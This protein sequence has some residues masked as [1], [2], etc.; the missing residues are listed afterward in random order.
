MLDLINILNMTGDGFCRFALAMFIQSGILIALL[1]LI[2]LLIRKYVRAVFRYC[3]WMLVFIKLILPPTLC[4]PTGIGYWCS[5]DISPSNNQ[6]PVNAPML[7]TPANTNPIAALPSSNLPKIQPPAIT[8]NITSLPQIQPA[9]LNTSPDPAIPNPP[10]TWQ[11]VVFLIWLVGVLILSVLLLQ[12]FL[13]VKSLL[14]QTALADGRLDETLQQCR[15]QL[16]T[17]QNVKLRLSQNMLSPAACGLF[18]PVILMS[19]SLLENLSKEKLTAILI[20]ELAH[21]K[22]GD[23]WINFIQT[24]LQILYFYN[25]FVWFANSIVRTI[26]E[27]AVDEMVLTKLGDQAK[28]YSSTLIDIAELAFSKPH[29]SLRLVGVVESKKALSD[30]IKHIL[31]RPIPK[32]AKLGLVGL[33]M[34]ILA[35]CVL[36]PMAKGKETKPEFVVKDTVKDSQISKLTAEEL[37]NSTQYKPSENQDSKT[38]SISAAQTNVSAKD[39]NKVPKEENKSSSSNYAAALHKNKI[40]AFTLSNDGL[41]ALDWDCSS[42]FSTG[43]NAKFIGKRH[44]PDL[45]VEY[46]IYFPADCD[47]ETN[48]FFYGSS[49]YGGSGL[50][51]GLNLPDYNSFDIKFTLRKINDS[52][53]YKLVKLPLYAGVFVSTANRK[54]DVKYIALK[55]NRPAVASLRTQMEKINSLGILIAPPRR[56]AGLDPNLGLKVTLLLQPVP[57]AKIIEPIK[58]TSEMPESSGNARE[59]VAG[60]DYQKIQDA[61][62]AAQYGDNV[63]IKPGI[64]EESLKLKDGVNLIGEDTN[65]VIIQCDFREA[66]V[67]TIENCKSARISKMTL[68]HYSSIPLKDDFAGRWAVIRLASSNAFLEH[69]LVCD[70]SSEG[71]RI[72]NNEKVVVNKCTVR[73]SRTLGILVCASGRTELDNNICENNKSNGIYFKGWSSGIVSGNLC[74][75]NA[76]NGISIDDNAAVNLAANTCSENKWSGIWL[77]AKGPLNV[78]SNIC[79]NNEKTGIEINGKIEAFV[80]GNNCNRNSNNG[81]Y[82]LGGAGG[83]AREN[84]CNANKIH[85]ISIDDLS[86]PN[87]K[88]NNCSDNRRCGVYISTSGKIQIGLNK[89]HNNGEFSIGEIHSLLQAEDFNELE[90]MASKIRNEKRRFLDGNWQLN[91]FYWTLGIGY[92]SSKQKLI[93]DIFKKWM[94]QYPDSITPRICMAYAYFDFAWNARGGGFA[95][96]VSEKGWRE[97]KEFLQKAK[98][99]LKDAEKFPVKDPGLYVILLGIERG[100]GT[101]PQETQSIFEK[102]VAIES[103]YYP[104]YGERATSYMMR[105]YGK[106]GDLER[107]AQDAVSRTKNTEGQILY[108]LIAEQEIRKSTSIEDFKDMGFNYEQLKQGQQELVKRFPEARNI[109]FLNQVCF[110]ACAA[111]NKEDAKDYFIDIGDQW[112]KNIWKDFETFSKYKSWAKSKNDKTGS[113]EKSSINPEPN[114]IEIKEINDSNNKSDSQAVMIFEKMLAKYKEIKTFSAVGEV[115]SVMDMSDVNIPDNTSDKRFQEAMKNFKSTYSFTIKLGRPNLYLVKWE[116]KLVSAFSI[117]SEGAVWNAGDGDYLLLLGQKSKPQN[118]EMALASA[119]GVSGGAAATIPSLFFNMPW[120]NIKS[121]QGLSQTGEEKIDGDDCYIISGKLA[122]MKHKLWISKQTFLIRQKQHIFNGEEIKPPSLS[123]EDIKTSLKAMGKDTNPEEIAKMRETMQSANRMASKIKA[124]STTEIYLDIKIDEAIPKE[125]FAPDV[126]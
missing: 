119:T 1:Y 56:P 67:L 96:T 84:I 101:L 54:S 29:F 112:D 76:K 51:A 110:T 41:M 123:D 85:G 40:R 122:N 86:T 6:I 74:R 90:Y 80:I 107:F 4:L 83:S 88:D 38:N 33:V 19:A 55:P 44:I 78:R 120:G 21:I 124:G 72:E 94:S 121:M 22:R 75:N 108:F 12:K 66:P 36:L 15:R 43:T 16:P 98:D 58:Q 71:I 95:Y 35:G 46:D 102:G 26:R 111:E 63:R 103:N 17:R 114:T 81:I 62:N 60:R 118:A 24:I 7:V 73:N 28:T 3:I 49:M 45:G 126:N 92:G 87:V 91:S 27:K 69:L 113:E 42:W 5:L 104:L 23:L 37:K 18:N 61:I 93:E 11:A 9:E 64:Y 100:L 99:I 31:T 34:I 13:F 116:Q 30:R 59:L 82:F 115:N 25:P 89:I 39:A 105:W 106:E 10:M 14:A 79:N 48:W 65:T 50:L 57:K 32:S 109:K 2:D 53:D 47:P 70:S 8:E 97:C 20:H 52:N 68:K 117:S 125:K 77:G